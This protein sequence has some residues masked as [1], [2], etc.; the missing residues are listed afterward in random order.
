M[1]NGIHGCRCFC[2]VQVRLPLSAVAASGLTGCLL[3]FA[4]SFIP[5]GF[6]KGILLVTLFICL[7]APAWREAKPPS[8]CWMIPR[9]W[10]AAGQ[11]RYSCAV[12]AVLGVGFATRVTTGALY[13][14]A[15]LAAGSGS[16]LQA[17]FIFCCVGIGR[18]VPIIAVGSC[19]GRHR[20]HPR[21]CLNWL[22]WSRPIPALLTRGGIGVVLGM[23]MG[24]TFSVA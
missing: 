13:A 11:G 23:I 1:T 2:G 3:G 6:W 15:L 18:A 19:M 20:G 14:V 10:M 16:L 17:A 8:G 24:M 21:E 12:G 9:R 22:S 7:V 5:T 4:G